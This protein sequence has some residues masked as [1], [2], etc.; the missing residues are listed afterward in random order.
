MYYCQ[1]SKVMLVILVIF[2]FITFSYT[3]VPNE[4]NELRRYILADLV[5]TDLEKA[6]Q[7]TDSLYAKATNQRDVIRT[8]MVVAVL[9]YQKGDI[10]QALNIATDS[11]KA[12]MENKNYSDQISVIGF[13]A[14][15]FRELGL[16]TEALYYLEK[17]ETSLKKLEEG[18]LKGQ[19]G[20]L[21]EH[22]KIAIYSEREEYDKVLQHVQNAY[23]YVEQIEAGS[24]KD[25]FLAT[26]LFFGA[27]NAYNLKEYERSRGLILDAEKVLNNEKEIL[28]EEIQLLSAQLDMI[29]EEYETAKI[30]IEQVG[31]SIESSQNFRLKKSYYTVATD[32]YNQINESEAYVEHYKKLLEVIHADERRSQKVAN[33]SLQQLRNKVQDQRQLSRIRLIVGGVII[34]VL[35]SVPFLMYIRNKKRTNRY[36]KIMSKLRA[37]QLHE[38]IT[39]TQRNSTSN[40]KINS[41]TFQYED[42]NIS[43]ETEE[44][45]YTELKELEKNSEFYLQPEVS[46]TRLSTLLNTNTKYLSYVI[47]KY[48]EKNFNNYINDLRIYYI[49]KQL[50]EKSEYSQYKISYLAQETGFSSHSKFSS[51]F[52]RVTG[53][54]PSVFIK[55]L[56][57]EEA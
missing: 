25:H 56:E 54:A 16:N 34:I 30:K 49:L 5:A 46:L 13:I 22:E 48:Y 2:S 43:N 27:T 4:Y 17:A 14:A 31:K 3:Q 23:K 35:L 15:N 29:E 57:K 51:E 12:F 45:I 50:Q 39:D 11:E 21:L 26:T 24:N 42:L 41:N 10:D 53:I 7:Y 18:S 20:T 19:Y 40:K 32:F 55:K 1:R 37:G 52:K 44:R 47:R 33:R 38:S 8:D 28:Y 36:K 9:H 6:F